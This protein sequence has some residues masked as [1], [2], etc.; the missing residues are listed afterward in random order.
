VSTSTGHR[1]DLWVCQLGTVPYRE[2]L[3]LQVRVRAARQAGDVP[4]TLLLL[5]HLPVYTRGRRAGAQDL[6]FA[7]SFYRERGIE[8]VDTDRG[9]RIT[10]HGPG[11]LVGYPIMGVADVGRFVRTM[12]AAIVDALAAEG[13]PAHARADEGADFTGVW[14]GAKA[15]DDERGGGG[16]GG[17][18]KI[19]SIGVHVQRG[20]STHGF[21]VNVVNDL[22]PW[23]WI[24]PCGLQD[25]QMTS[26]QRERP[27]PLAPPGDAAACAARL[28][29]F[30]RRAADSF[31]RAHD[32]RQRIVTPQALERAL[33]DPSGR[34][35]G[36]APLEAVPVP[37]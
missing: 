15:D 10:Y 18:R 7:P 8:I 20:V 9:G 1:E 19:A 2:A 26:L 5:E 31:C 28:T 6:P 34:A 21:A 32:R 33:R 24:V 23:E 13:L 12:E 29:C 35:A 3:D 22:A 14:V 30:R 37:A 4:D 36:R 11:Q 16:G 17:E 27:D 25:V